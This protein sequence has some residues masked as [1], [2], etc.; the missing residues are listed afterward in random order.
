MNANKFLGDCGPFLAACEEAI[1]EEWDHLVIWR[2]DCIAG[3]PMFLGNTK[4][5]AS[6]RE[7]NEARLEHTRAG[8]ARQ[9]AERLDS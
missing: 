5:Y 9:V 1:D 3:N 7:K 8:I 4:Y 6:I 2:L